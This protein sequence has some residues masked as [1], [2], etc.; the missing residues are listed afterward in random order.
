MQPIGNSLVKMTL[1]GQQ[2]YN[3]LEQQFPGLANAQVTPPRFLQVSGLTNVWDNAAT[4]G[5]KILEVR[6]KPTGQLLDNATNYT[7]TVNS[8]LAAGGDG[9]VEF[10][11]GTARV[12]GPLDLDA[13]IQYLKAQPQ[14]IGSI[15]D[16]RISRVN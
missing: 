3:V 13:L 5:S 4:A 16:G 7:V 15:T 1:I 10:V 14:P 6:V 11:N 2:I 12:G 8:F 9:L